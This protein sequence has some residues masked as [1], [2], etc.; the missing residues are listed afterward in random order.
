V[1]ETLFWLP[2]EQRPYAECSTYAAGASYPKDAAGIPLK[3]YRGVYQ[4]NPVIM[5][6][7]GLEWLHCYRTSQDPQYLDQARTVA[8][9]LVAMATTVNGALFFPYNYDF[10][11]HGVTEDT[12]H[13]PWY[14]GMAQGQVLSLFSRLGELTGEVEW[15]TDADATLLSFDRWRYHDDPWI[16]DLDAQGD[17]WI[18]EY[19]F[20]PEERALN[21]FIFALFGLYDYAV[22]REDAQAAGMFLQSAATLHK[23]VERFRNPGERSSYCL[24]HRVQSTSYHAIHIMQLRAM[25][26]MT[27]DPYFAG[28]ADLFAADSP[29]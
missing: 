14:S 9:A 3:L 18:E 4:Y 1:G 12:L 22:W 26:D 13:A 16:T 20:T 21:V 15:Q 10:S 8:R 19:P 5:A 28:V 7:A 17:V 24:A 23:N 27:G 11:L 25:T 6:Q 29:P 2:I